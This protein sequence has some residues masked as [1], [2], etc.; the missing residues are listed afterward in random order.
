VPVKRACGSRGSCAIAV[1]RGV[2]DRPAVVHPLTT[3]LDT[4]QTCP[5]RTARRRTC[6][7]R[8]RRSRAHLGSPQ[9]ADHLARGRP[10]RSHADAIA[11]C[12]D[13][14]ESTQC[15]D[16]RRTFTRRFVRR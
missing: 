3:R 12:R 14:F 6:E 8:N 13:S 2:S 10:R 9:S 15:V 7:V 1:R 5:L 4:R 16:D 11:R